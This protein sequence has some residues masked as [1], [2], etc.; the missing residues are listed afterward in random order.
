MPVTARASL[1]DVI[2]EKMQA[3]PGCLDGLLLN[4]KGEPFV[5][6]IHGDDPLAAGFDTCSGP[7]RRAPVEDPAVTWMD[8][9]DF[10]LLAVL[11]VVA[12]NARFHM[13]R[14]RDFLS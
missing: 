2:R 8:V 4:E 3:S 11:V 5:Q 7:V 1:Q 12:L 10:V 13:P 14:L 9:L 6:A